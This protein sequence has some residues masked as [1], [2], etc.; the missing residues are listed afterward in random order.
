MDVFDK[1]KR[2]KIMASVKSENTKPEL[3][4][5]RFLWSNGIRYRVHPRFLPGKPDIAI[6]RI[7]LAVFVH[8]CFWHGHEGCLKAHLPKTRVAYWED[9][10]KNNK[11]RDIEIEKILKNVGWDFLVIWQCHIKNEKLR[12]ETL[13]KVLEN[14][15]NRFT[16]IRI[17]GRGINDKK[18]RKSI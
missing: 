17:K 3:I 11:T 9:K 4:V 13:P 2:S 7:K 1:A 16:F 5:R 14:I 6:T 8:G 10:I 12:S 15:R 18:R